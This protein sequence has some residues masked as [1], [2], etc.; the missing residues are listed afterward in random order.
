MKAIFCCAVAFLSSMAASG[1]YGIDYDPDHPKPKTASTIVPLNYR[2]FRMTQPDGVVRLFARDAG[3]L[4][5]LIPE[6]GPWTGDANPGQVSIRTQDGFKGGHTEFLFIDGVLRMMLLENRKVPVQPPEAVVA[7]TNGIAALWPD[8]AKVKRMEKEARAAIWGDPNRW[9]FGF[10]N[11]NVAGALIACLSVVAAFLCLSRN[12]IVAG[13]GVAATAA[14]MFCLAKTQSRS[15]FVSFF[16]GCLPLAVCYLR[17]RFSWRKIAACL[18]L[19]AVA[20]GFGWY[21]MAGRIDVRQAGLLNQDDDTSRLPIWRAVPRMCVAAPGGWGSGETGK[22]YNNWF[23]PPEREHKLNGLLSSHFTI[24][25]ERGWTGRFLYVFGWFTLLALLWAAAMRGSNPLPAAT[26]TAF[27][28]AAFFNHITVFRS[29]WIIPIASL[30]PFLA[31]RPWRERRLCLGTASMAAGLAGLVLTTIWWVGSIDD[32]AADIPGIARKGDATL[33]NGQEPKHWLVCDEYVLDGGFRGLFGKEL[34]SFYSRKPD[35]PALG[36]VNSIAALPGDVDT[37][38]LAGMSAKKFIE[39][40]RVSPDALPKVDRLVLLSPPF[41]WSDVPGEF[42]SAYKTELVTGD[43]AARLAPRYADSPDWVYL[44]PGAELY[45]PG[46][47]S[48]V[49]SEPSG[50][51]EQTNIQQKEK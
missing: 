13:A 35:A 10:V 19:V 33:V 39:R 50:G 18:F 28:T 45:V 2:I 47:Q 29:L 23:Q 15:G 1:Y 30:I 24:L 17:T 40:W 44:A 12:R 4:S 6:S 25:A 49:L 9:K 32:D 16:A 42:L 21:S 34:R 8:R 5:T 36:C 20:T 7:T 22:A 27:F 14:L 3:D 26:W 43:F 41:P 38:V 46:W 11:P 31:S 48:F 51:K 37:L